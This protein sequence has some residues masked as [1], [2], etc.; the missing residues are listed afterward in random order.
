MIIIF[1]DII[2]IIHFFIFIFILTGFFLIPIGY[3]FRW[4]WVKNKKIRVIHLFLMFFVTLE[5]IFGI[6]C[7]LTTIEH[8]LRL[9]KEKGVFVDIIHKIM[10]WDFPIHYF[11]ISYFICF[12]Y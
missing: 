4:G 7:P 11:I 5:T 9:N 8:N 6:T 1:A 12:I 10:Y 2:L 3:Q